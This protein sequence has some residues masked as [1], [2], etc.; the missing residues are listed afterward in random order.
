MWEL[1]LKDL[2][3]VTL[4]CWPFLDIVLQS[5]YWSREGH[6]RFVMQ[7]FNVVRKGEMFEI[8]QQ[9]YMTFYKTTAGTVWV[10]WQVI[11]TTF[12]LAN[13]EVFLYLQMTKYPAECL[14]L[15]FFE[16]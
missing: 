11:Q 7:I 1:D 15:L 12:L 4:Y 16:I 9:D 13:F 8:E 5:F 3:C 14:V 2:K 10:H 6:L